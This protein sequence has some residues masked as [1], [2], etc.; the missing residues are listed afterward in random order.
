MERIGV[1]GLGRMGSAIARRMTS[2]GLSVTAWTRSGRSVD[3]VKSAPDLETLV[4]HSDTLILS[5]LDDAAVA[6][7]LDAILKH[8]LTGK[9]IIETSTVTPGLLIDRIDVITARG[10]SAVDAP[11]SGGP[12]L[13]MAGACGVFIGGDAASAARAQESL[14]PI[15]GRVF[16]VGPLGAGLV[17]K[18]VNNGM[19]QAY[20]AG[21]ADLMPLARAAG[22]S[23]ETVMRILAGGPAGLPMVADR[24]PRILGEDKSVGFDIRSTF[25]DNRI[26]QN[27]LKSYGLTSPTLAR[28]RM[29]EDAVDKAGFWER[30]AAALVS[31]AYYGGEDDQAG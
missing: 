18:V 23:L 27:V 28:Y 17:M 26:F 25:K 2:E 21:L 16:H 11:I 15:S 14:R 4:E 20:I 6:E 13:V 7:M 24:I 31:L 5:L 3:G 30:D 10:A 22:L 9:Q 1:I 12:E 29:Q 8:D 19:L